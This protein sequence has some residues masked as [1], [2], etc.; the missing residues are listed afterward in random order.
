MTP[1]WRNLR[2]IVLFVKFQIIVS[3]V[4]A[5][6]HVVSTTGYKPLNDTGASHFKK[7]RYCKTKGFH[8]GFCSVG[9]SI[10]LQFSIASQLAA[11]ATK[12]EVGVALS[13]E[14]F[15]RSRYINFRIVRGCAAAPLPSHKVRIVLVPGYNSVGSGVPEFCVFGLATR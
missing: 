8:H 3:T 6:E 2:P 12:V 14:V 5:A 7:L 11:K 9:F 13:S 10:V 4:G 1:V 15:S